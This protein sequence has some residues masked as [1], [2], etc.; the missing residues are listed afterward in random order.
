MK[1]IFLTIAMVAFMASVTA[2]NCCQKSAEEAAP[3]EEV[4][5]EV[6]DS[7]K[8]ACEECTG[9]CQNCE[10]QCEQTQTAE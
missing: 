2:C 5:T 7:T 1:K 10:G 6:C 8:C 3:V 9:D 4:A